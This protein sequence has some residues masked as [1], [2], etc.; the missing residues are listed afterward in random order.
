MIVGVYFGGAQSGGDCLRVFGRLVK[1]RKPPVVE[2]LKI[3]QKADKRKGRDL[4]K[5]HYKTNIVRITKNRLY[6]WRYLC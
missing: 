1:S 4:L 5:K 2:V 6:L 3:R